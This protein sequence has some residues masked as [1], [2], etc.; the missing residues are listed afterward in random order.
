MRIWYVTDD[1]GAAEPEIVRVKIML[2]EP[3][4]PP[5]PAE[6]PGTILLKPVAPLPA[7]ATVMRIRLNT[8]P[9]IPAAPTRFRLAKSIAPPPASAEE[10]EGVAP[11]AA[12]DGDAT[13]GDQRDEGERP[14]G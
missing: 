12:A 9:P 1:D 3:A 10:R 13:A 14:A 2:L 5:I 8:A 4:A 7:P 6:P 11:A